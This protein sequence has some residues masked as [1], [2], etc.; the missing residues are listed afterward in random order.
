[1]INSQNALCCLKW[2]LIWAQ[3]YRYININEE[4]RVAISS[5]IQERRICHRL[6]R[7]SQWRHMSVLESQITKTSTIYSTANSAHCKH[8]NS[9]LLDP[10][11]RESNSDRWTDEPIM[12][13][14]SLCHDIFMDTI[15]WRHNMCDCVSNHQPH[16]CLLNQL[17]R[18]R[19]KKTSNVT[20]LNAGNSKGT[21]EFPAQRA[22]TRQ[23]FL[24]HDVIMMQ[25][26]I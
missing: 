7:A 15:W 16:D 18:R 2:V 20:G 19:S 8:Q 9:A 4:S 26:D 22:V 14:V 11:W 5:Q 6:I 12:L 24:F 10:L 23:M 3:K 25:R 13:K 17:F 1:M 21:G